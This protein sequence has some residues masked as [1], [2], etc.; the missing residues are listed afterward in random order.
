MEGKVCFNETEV[1]QENACVIEFQAFRGNKGEYIIKELV[2]LDLL[3]CV[4][5]PFLFEPPF[6]FSKLNAKSKK[7]NKWMI[8]N[9]HNI[10]WYEGFTSYTNLERVL[11]HFCNKFTKV[12]TRGQEKRNW[13]QMY[14]KNQVF[15]VKLDKSFEFDKCACICIS[16]KNDQHKKSQCALKN[17]YRLAAFLHSIKGMSGGG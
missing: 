2:I 9:F 14:T 4:V 5:Y 13:I 8:K 6:S 3:T 12:Y 1:I 16:V 7:T 15:D 10:K 17:A 11:Y